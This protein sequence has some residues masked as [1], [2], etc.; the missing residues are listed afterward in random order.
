MPI[1]KM[2]TATFKITMKSLNFADSLMPRTRMADT[3]QRIATAT[4]LTFPGMG[5]NGEAT[6]ARGSSIPNDIRM[7]SNVAAQLTE[8]VAAP[9]AYSNTNAQPIIQATSSPSVAYE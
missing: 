2:T 3:T 8:T 9:T 7:E 6:R 1:K 5:S 4:K